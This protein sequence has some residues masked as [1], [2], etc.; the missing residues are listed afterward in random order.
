MYSDVVEVLPDLVVAR[1]S[2]TNSEEVVKRATCGTD[3]KED[4]VTERCVIVI[5]HSQS[6]IL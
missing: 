6:A 5:L 3:Q 1:D 2:V 4:E